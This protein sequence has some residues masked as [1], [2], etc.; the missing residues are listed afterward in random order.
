MKSK[1]SASNSEAMASEIAGLAEA[2]TA[3]LKRRWRLL[4]ESAGAKANRLRLARRGFPPKLQNPPPFLAL[5]ALRMEKPPPSARSF[6][7]LQIVC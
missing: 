2:T 1:I 3:E 6:G 4:H 5:R 7:L